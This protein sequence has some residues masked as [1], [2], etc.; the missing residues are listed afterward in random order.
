MDEIN[1]T[2]AGLFQHTMDI[3]LVMTKEVL[4]IIYK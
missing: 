3:G 4:Q 1:G 2:T